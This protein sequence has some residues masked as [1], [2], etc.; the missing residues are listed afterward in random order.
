[1]KAFL[2]TLLCDHKLNEVIKYFLLFAG[3]RNYHQNKKL[4]SVQKF[5]VQS[6]TSELFGICLC[7]LDSL[8]TKFL[9]FEK[10]CLHWYIKNI[11]R[12]TKT[13]LYYVE[14]IE[15]NQ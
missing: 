11:N 6:R 10:P 1:M 2:L 8:A 13:A 3:K 14:Y 12:I 9:H 7:L 5:V 15:M 4:C